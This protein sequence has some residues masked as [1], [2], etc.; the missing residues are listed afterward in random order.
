MWR[1]RRSD[2]LAGVC[3]AADFLLLPKGLAPVESELAFQSCILTVVRHGP[4]YLDR[5]VIAG[6]GPSMNSIALIYTPENRR[7]FPRA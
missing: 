2:Q 3:C 6:Y 1:G 7:F 4:A 5:A